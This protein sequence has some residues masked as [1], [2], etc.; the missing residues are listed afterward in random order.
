MTELITESAYCTSGNIL[1]LLQCNFAGHKYLKSHCICAPLS[2]TCDHYS[3]NFQVKYVNFPSSKVLKEN[4]YK[5]DYES[6]IQALNLVDWSQVIE[7]CRENVQ[8]LYDK[9]YVD[10][11]LHVINIYVP[12]EVKQQKLRQLRH[13]SHLLKEKLHLYNES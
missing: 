13:I 6:I 8:Q 9:L 10:I 12:I 4:F 1:D 5:A 3:I 7:D 11:L 2:D